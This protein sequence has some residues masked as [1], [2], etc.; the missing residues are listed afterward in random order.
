MHKGCKWKNKCVNG[1]K[2]KCCRDTRGTVAA[3]APNLLSLSEA[4]PQL[5]PRRE[6]LPVAEVEGHFLAGISGHQ[7]GAVLH[8][9]VGRLHVP[10]ETRRRPLR[11]DQ[12]ARDPVT[13]QIPARRHH[14]GEAALFAFPPFYDTASRRTAA[15][16]NVRLVTV[17]DGAWRTRRRLIWV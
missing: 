8:R 5:S 11:P 10:C 16:V 13:P 14:M 7:R 6:F 4:D 17:H 3:S 1:L 12:S 9:L 2:K 15:D